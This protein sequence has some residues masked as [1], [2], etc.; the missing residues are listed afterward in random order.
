MLFFR[1][2]DFLPW[3]LLP[4][5]LDCFPSVLVWGAPGLYT[6][7]G[8]SGSEEGKGLPTVIVRVGTLPGSGMDHNRSGVMSGSCRRSPLA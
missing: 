3:C 7:V 6:E 2:G 8:G 1:E 5:V 4:S